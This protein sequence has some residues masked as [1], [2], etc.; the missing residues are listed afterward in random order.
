MK[1]QLL[2]Y[3]FELTVIALVGYIAAVGVIAIVR[4]ALWL[5]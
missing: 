5:L 2:C 4:G 3:G 1:K